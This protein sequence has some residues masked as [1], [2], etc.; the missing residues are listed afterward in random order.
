MM[1]SKYAS[2]GLILI[3]VTGSAFSADP[4][5]YGPNNTTTA[6]SATR[7][8]RIADGTGLLTEPCKIS[9]LNQ[10]IDLRMNTTPSDARE[11]CVAYVGLMAKYGMRF[12]PG[13]TLRFLPPIKTSSPLAECA[14]PG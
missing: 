5:D 6:E 2:C 7:F 9:V 12:N 11:M 14:L 1:H 4:A 10:S 8:C 3:V 13:W